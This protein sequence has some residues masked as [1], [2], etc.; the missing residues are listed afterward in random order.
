MILAGIHDLNA[1]FDNS[2]YAA[3]F[4]N[5]SFGIA[6][7]ISK[8]A[9]VS[10]FNVTSP[11]L[12]LKYEPNAHWTFLAGIWDGYPGTPDENERGFGLRITP[13]EGY[14]NIVEVQHHH[15]LFGSHLPG[16]IKVG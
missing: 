8:N 1:D 3:F 16:T 6:P 2:E 15:H 7:D 4:S 14:M 10:I 13:R 9:P 5:S 12:R 11:A